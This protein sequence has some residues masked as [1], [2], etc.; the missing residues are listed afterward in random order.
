[1][2]QLKQRKVRVSAERIRVLTDLHTVH[3]G[4]G[5]ATNTSGAGC[6]CWPDP[7]PR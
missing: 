5:K 4:I 1:M 3:G 6:D 7:L 2:K